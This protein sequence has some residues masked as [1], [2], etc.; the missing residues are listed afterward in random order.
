M[1]FSYLLS[2]PVKKREVFPMRKN[3]K[4]AKL[5]LEPIVAG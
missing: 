3:G 2:K 1:A 5:P 4:N